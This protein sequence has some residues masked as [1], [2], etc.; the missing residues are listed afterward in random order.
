MSFGTLNRVCHFADA[1]HNYVAGPG[2][3]LKARKTAA[4]VKKIEE[5]EGALSCPN[6]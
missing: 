1:Q 5:K 6:C 2:L 4:K 3:S